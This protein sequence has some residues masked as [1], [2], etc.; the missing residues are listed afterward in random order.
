MGK[1][2][3][4]ERQQKLFSHTN[5][6]YINLDKENGSKKTLKATKNKNKMGSTT[7]TFIWSQERIQSTNSASC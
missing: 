2:V 5:I 7:E 4:V 1:G 3:R 6:M